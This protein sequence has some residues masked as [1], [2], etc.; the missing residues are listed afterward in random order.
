DWVS[1]TAE[2]LGVGT[3]HCLLREGG[4]IADLLEVVRPDGPTPRQ[5]HAS[6]WVMLRSSVFDGTAEQLLRALAR[7]V[8][9][10]PAH[11]VDAFGVD[12][13]LVHDVLGDRPFTDLD[14]PAAMERMSAAPELREA[15]V[16]TSA[17]LRSRL[18]RYLDSVLEPTDGRIVLCDIGWG[19]TIQESLDEILRHEGRL[20]RGNDMIGLYLSLSTAGDRRVASGAWMLGYLPTDATHERQRLALQRTPEILEQLCTPNT[21]TLL[22][23]DE[24]GSPVT[25]AADATWTE[26]RGRA[27]R[28]TRDMVA[29]LAQVEHDLAARGWRAG[30]PGV[31]SRWLDPG[32]RS[33]LLRGVAATL[34][35]PTQPLAR[36]LSAWL[37]DDVA[38]GSVVPLARPDD[39]GFLPYLSGAEIDTVS[40]RDVFWLPGAAAAANPALAAQLTAAS[41]GVDPEALSPPSE[42]GT[43]TI[44]VYEPGVQDAVAVDHPVPRVDARGWSLLRLAT[45]ARAVRDIRI[46]FGDVEH[47]VELDHLTITFRRGAGNGRT[48]TTWR[49][50]R[51]DD[52][53][54][55]WVRGRTIGAARAAVRAGGH[56]IVAVTGRPE[57]MSDHVEI[58]CAFRTSTL[59]REDA[60]A[61]L[62]SVA[63]ER[64]GEL[65]HRVRMGLERR[66]RNVLTRR[67]ATDASEDSPDRDGFDGQTS[68]SIVLPIYETPHEHLEQQLHSIREQTHP[69][70]ECVVVDD[71]SHDAGPREIVERFVGADPRF[72]LHVRDHNGG[73]AAATNDALDRARNDWIVFVD[74]DDVIHRDALATIAGHIAEHPDDDV[75]YTDEQTIDVAGNHILDYRKPDYSSERLLGH[76]YFCHIVT[77]RR[78]LVERVGRLDPEVEPFTDNDFNLRAVELAQEV[79][80]IPR[81]LYSWRAIPGSVAS[82]IDEKPGAARSVMTATERALARRGRTA[83]ARSVPGHEANVTITD[84]AVD[85]T[86]EVIDVGDA[87]TPLEIDALLRASTAELVVL[88]PDGVGITADEVDRLAALCSLPGVAVVGPRL[89]TT[90]G[91]LVSAG[92]VH[93][94]SFGDV[95]QGDPA[96]NPGPWGAFLVTR[97][98]SSVSPIGAMLDRRAVLDAGGFDLPR[99]LGSGD[100]EGSW[101]D[102]FDLARDDVDVV[103]AL[104]CTRL[105]EFGRTTLCTPLVTLEVSTRFVL[106]ADATLRRSERHRLLVGSFPRV[107]T[108]LYSPTGTGALS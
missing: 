29:Q 68:F 69:R 33:A 76:N 56:L 108:E 28:A 83:A 97:E 4:F 36:T 19:G 2:E 86:T 16:A 38:G 57:A 72:S 93:A 25:A 10:D 47:L 3:V 46:D 13:R 103:M 54:L 92:R 23:I 8:D 107:G 24:D 51:L 52:P 88:A 73:I 21:G 58:E 40:M 61:L 74:H 78:S 9:F 5:V 104:V 35:S 17:E 30:G 82:S 34:E 77:M 91:R 60:T 105:R 59:R 39:L 100:D 87:A 31:P 80:H 7:N 62:P 53:R 96:D 42:A 81:I 44:A 99:L 50:E 98:V 79:G 71:G 75:V 64:A 90:D 63:R 6:R 45:S 1:R 70:W 49:I 89:V 66:A 67:A 55:R 37:H 43:A 106:D 20:T 14:R 18:L 102:S 48:A 11:V 95:F 41:R 84:A 27:Q 85:V 65:T 94:P 101:D 22:D 12:E 15:I 26:T 32:M